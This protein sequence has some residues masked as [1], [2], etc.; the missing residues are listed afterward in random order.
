MNSDTLL[1]V[2]RRLAALPAPD[3]EEIMRELQNHLEDKAAALQSQGVERHDVAAQAA[4]GDPASVGARLAE[5]H[6]RPTA[7]QMLLAVL[8]F[9]MN[10]LLTPASALA[11]AALDRALGPAAGR[12]IPVVTLRLY[13]TESIVALAVIVLAICALFALGTLIGLVRGLPLWSAS[14]I[15]STVL[16]LVFFMQGV[17]DEVSGATVA[18]ANLALIVGLLAA[19]SFVARWRSGVLALLIALSLMLQIRIFIVYALA[20]YPLSISAV[21]LSFTVGMVA[22]AC[23]ATVAILT[24]RSG[25]LPLALAVALLALSPDLLQGDAGGFIG[26]DAVSVLVNYLLPM[27]LF[28]PYLLGRRPPTAE[29]SP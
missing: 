23:F 20:E 4:F 28:L 3:Q 1:I 12:P 15:G 13:H 19:L 2:R 21:R 17:L 9:I 14:W 24:W 8:P 10:G 27:I 18:L 25:H 5:I 26:G 29:H 6:N 16:G 7:R 11:V 22:L